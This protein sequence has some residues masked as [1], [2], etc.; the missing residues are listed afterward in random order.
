MRYIYIL[1]ASLIFSSFAFADTVTLEWSP[2]SEQDLSGYRV[3][4]RT[5]ESGYDYTSP[6]WQGTETTCKIENLMATEKYHFVVRAFDT[7]GYESG[8]SNEVAYFMGTIPDGLPP[9]KVKAVKIT[10]TVTIP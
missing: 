10:I 1:F 2:N 5:A 6:T 7:E 9:G 3:F 8:N 4:H